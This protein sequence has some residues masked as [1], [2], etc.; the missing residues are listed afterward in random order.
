MGPAGPLAG[1]V[2]GSHRP[3]LPPEGL[4]ALWRER[5][6]RAVGAGARLG[7][8]REPAEACG[9]GAGARRRHFCLGWK[10]PRRRDS[11]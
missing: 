1:P 4:L 3:P 5:P 8:A 7:V 10:K 11:W 6:R 2:R 9:A